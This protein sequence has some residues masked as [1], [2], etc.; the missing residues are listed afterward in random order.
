M[1]NKRILL[2]AG[3]Y[4]LII[5]GSIIYAVG[6]SYITYPNDV[7]TGGING[8]SMIINAFTGLPVGTM[9]I[10]LNI[11]LFIIAWIKFGRGFVIASLAGTVLSSLAVDALNLFPYVLT[12]EPLFICVYGGILMGVGLGIV[13]RVGATTGGTEIIVKLLKMKYA[14]INTGTIMFIVD[15][16][17]ICA[18]SVIFDK[19]NSALYAL[20]TIFLMTKALDIVLYGFSQSKLCYII[21]DHS[22]ELKNAILIRLDRGVT[23]LTGHGG[24]SGEQK[25]ILMCVIKPRQIVE[26]RSIAKEFDPNAFMIINDAKEVFGE[27]FSD[28]AEFK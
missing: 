23:I 4:F 21:T 8:V 25:H 19:I 11:P 16:I 6:F 9:S 10:I 14:H 22:E 13:Y 12:T 27:G 5:L 1:K 24:Y 18:Y 26:L 15:F 3:K 7:P 28:N 17:I 2:T 20:I